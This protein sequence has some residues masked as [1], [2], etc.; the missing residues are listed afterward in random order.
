MY[1]AALDDGVEQS[2]QAFYSITRVMQSMLT[3]AKLTKHTKERTML[4]G[5]TGNIATRLD[6]LLYTSPTS[7]PDILKAHLDPSSLL[8]RP[9]LHPPRPHINIF[10]RRA[11]PSISTLFP[12]PHLPLI[13]HRD[14]AAA[15]TALEQIVPTATRQL[16]QMPD[17]C[18]LQHGEEPAQPH[19]ARQCHGHTVPVRVAVA[20]HIR[21]IGFLALLAETVGGSPGENAGAEQARKAG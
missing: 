2:N 7:L 1:Q 15:A 9:I 8:L 17:P 11:R 21:G 12:I 18:S 10:A 4:M 3:I 19:P 16:V 5:I 20:Q 6:D 14:T 13:L